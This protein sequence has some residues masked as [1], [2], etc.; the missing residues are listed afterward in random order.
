[1][2][3]V[4]LTVITIIIGITRITI[5]LV[6]YMIVPSSF[7]NSLDFRFLISAMG[8]EDLVNTESRV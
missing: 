1:M 5:I 7:I 4:V 2:V 8:S 3:V 6:C